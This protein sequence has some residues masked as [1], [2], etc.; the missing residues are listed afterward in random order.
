MSCANISV[1][2]NVS[3]IFDY[4]IIL[5]LFFFF[6]SSRRRHTRC[7]RDW[8]SDVCSSDL[9]F[10]VT[11]CKCVLT[12]RRYILSTAKLELQI[13]DGYPTFYRLAVGDSANHSFGNEI[14][15]QRADNG[16]S[17][18]GTYS[19]GGDRESGVTV[20]VRVIGIDGSRNSG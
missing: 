13:T 5:L 18:V 7:S 8:S 17:E 19:V 12:N 16:N 11:A 10:A 9:R 14:C 4:Y 2:L 6:F 1:S 3:F 20:A 15:R